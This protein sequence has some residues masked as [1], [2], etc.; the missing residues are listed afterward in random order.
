MEEILNLYFK[1]E[2]DIRRHFSPDG[3]M[4]Y[5]LEDGRMYV[6]KIVESELWFADNIKE[7]E[8]ENCAV[9]EIRGSGIFV[10]DNLTAINIADDYMEGATLILDNSKELKDD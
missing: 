4:P 10:K 5:S 9:V 8:D 6:W 2:D 7:M 1:L 3:Y